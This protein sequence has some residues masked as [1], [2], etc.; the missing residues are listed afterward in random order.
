MRGSCQLLSPH[1]RAH[2]GI[3][4][5]QRRDS[6]P[7]NLGH[8]R[9]HRVSTFAYPGLF[10]CSSSWS[11]GKGR[12][13][14]HGQQDPVL[15]RGG[16]TLGAQGQ[17][18]FLGFGK[19]CAKAFTQRAQPASERP[20]PM[21]RFELPCPELDAPHCRLA[22]T[23]T[24]AHTHTQNSSLLFYAWIKQIHADISTSTIQVSA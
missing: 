20:L 24:H 2:T 9:G 4:R 15:A 13:W 23:C 14:E 7:D 19:L 1:F 17:F 3:G 12:H 18:A 16:C 8:W 11:E 22:R 5:R 10:F 21:L 6:A